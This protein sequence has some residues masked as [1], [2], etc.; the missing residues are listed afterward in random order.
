[1]VEISCTHVCKWKNG[2][3]ETIPGIWGGEVKENAGG[4][5]FYYDVL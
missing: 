4:S 2:S 1:M 3:V 5:K